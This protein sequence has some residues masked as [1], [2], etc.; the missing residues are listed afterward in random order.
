MSTNKYVYSAT[1]SVH[2]REVWVTDGTSAGTKILKDINPGTADSNPDTF[3][4]LFAGF[5]DAD[6]P[7]LS[8]VNLRADHGMVVPISFGTFS[9]FGIIPATIYSSVVRLDYG[10]TDGTAT[11]DATQR[12]TLAS[13]NQPSSL[14]WRNATTGALAE[15]TSKPGGFS[16]NTFLDVVD[17]DWVIG[18]TGDFNGDGKSNILWRNQTTSSFTEW[19]STGTGF[20]RNVYID[21]TVGADWSLTVKA[22]AA[23]V[24][25]PLR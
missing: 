12:F 9:G 6:G 18:G 17:R 15:W 20:A 22:G 5:T 24:L 13:A 25:I 1:D 19:E 10:V 21:D 4:V 8:V 3:M 14:M 23:P 2:G 7:R 16:P 11:T